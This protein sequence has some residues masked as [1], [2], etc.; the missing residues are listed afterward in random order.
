MRNIAF[1]VAMLATAIALGGALAHLLELPNK[2]GMSEGDYFTVQQAYRGWNRLA[3]VLLIELAS[4]AWVAILYWH[5]PPVRW[6]A[7]VAIAC[8][9]LA[10]LTFWTWTYPANVATS[11]WTRVPANWEQLRRQW[12]YSHAA[13]AIFQLL[14]TASLIIGVLSR[15]A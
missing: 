7:L 12:E 14:A 1:F 3:I 15:R 11:N 2:I 9:I 6:A 10:Q 8:L 13:G 5:Q 4:M